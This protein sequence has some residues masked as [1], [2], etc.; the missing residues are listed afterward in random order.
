[1]L[2]EIFL[3][4]S[5][6]GLDNSR[7]A[8]RPTGLMAGTHAGSRIAVEVLEKKNIVASV[9]I[10]LKLLCAAIHGSSAGAAFHECSDQALSQLLRYLE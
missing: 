1:M 8:P 6:V 7:D 4:Q 3:V 2:A 9:R 5:S 10:G